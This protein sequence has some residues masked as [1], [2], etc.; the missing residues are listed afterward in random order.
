MT[1]SK[2]V[3]M[4]R[5]IRDG[6]KN[7]RSSQIKLFQETIWNSET[8]DVSEAQEETLRQLAY[9]LDF[10]SPDS[11][12]RAEDPKLYGE[13]RLIQEIEAVLNRLTG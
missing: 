13:Q 9:D 11:G 4:L 6:D 10:Y 12:A 1:T 5:E 3:D 8:M 2:A 7:T